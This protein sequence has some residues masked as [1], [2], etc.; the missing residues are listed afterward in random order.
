MSLNA[1]S[2]YNQF[3]VTS[4]KINAFEIDIQPLSLSTSA[5][6]NIFSRG[7]YEH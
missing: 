6:F 3:F 7:N 4:P 2:M 1:H 5:E